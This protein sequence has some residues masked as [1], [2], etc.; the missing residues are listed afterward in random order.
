[1]KYWEIIADNLS[2]AGWSWGCVFSIFSSWS[3]ALVNQRSNNVFGS[4]IL[5][6]CS[7]RIFWVQF[8][9]HHKRKAT[10]LGQLGHINFCPSA[11]QSDF[12]LPKDSIV[13]KSGG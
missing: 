10:G 3:I 7:R 5:S 6:R 4:S 8:S 11:N 9:S 1:M 2:K 13:Q 12:P